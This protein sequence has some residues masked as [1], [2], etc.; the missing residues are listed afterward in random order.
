MIRRMPGLVALRD[1]KLSYLPHA[2]G[3][4]LTLGAVMV[5]VGLAYGELAGLPLAGLYGSMLPLVAYALFG[6]ARQLI[7]GPDSA[8]AAIV[9][10]TVVPLAHGDA[11]RLAALAADVGILVGGLCLLGAVLRLG[12]VA[13]F[14][15]TPVIVGFMHGLALVI[16]G[17]QLPRVLGLKAEGES[18]LG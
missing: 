14:L 11:G 15:S 3:A 18:T 7:V 9:A 12:F 16:V 10:V 13:N 1:Y 2:L 4:G 6:S 8:M 17:S 5:P